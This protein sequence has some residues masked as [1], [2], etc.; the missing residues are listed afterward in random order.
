MQFENCVSAEI[1][2]R[3]ATGK[4]TIER[5]N[6]SWLIGADGGRSVVRKTLGVSFL[7]ETRNDQAMVLA[8][9]R[10]LSAPSQVR[11]ALASPGTSD[12]LSGDSFGI[13]GAVGKRN[14]TI[15]S[16]G[17]QICIYVLFVRTACASGLPHRTQT[18]LAST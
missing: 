17:V 1:I 8:D 18:L 6:A 9:L 7:G 15:L 5:V 11:S 3:D 16:T 10:V 12:D 14:C 2:K 4:E 13:Y